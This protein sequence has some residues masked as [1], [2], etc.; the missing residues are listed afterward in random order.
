M[1]SRSSTTSAPN[2]G[3]IQNS[4]IRRPIPKNWIIIGAIIV[5]IIIAATAVGVIALAP[6][7]SVKISEYQISI[8]YSGSAL[9]YFGPATQTINSATSIAGGQKF[10]LILNITNSGSSVHQ[11]NSITAATPG[12]TVSSL[13]AT[14]PVL[15]S[16]SQTVSIKLTLQAPNSNF[17]GVMTL[18][19]SAS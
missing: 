9:G 4:R 19:V 14:M 3:P 16:P 12:F 11:V 10:P 5:F 1:I 17:A 8:T 18:T 15:V 6:K 13:N 7:P 2:S